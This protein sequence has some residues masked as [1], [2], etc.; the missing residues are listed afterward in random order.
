MSVVVEQPNKFPLG[1]FIGCGCTVLF[2]AVVAIVAAVVLGVFGLLKNSQ[3]F[4]DS[5]A[6]LSANSAAVEA[7]GEPIEAGFFVKGS[8]SIDND[9]GTADF[10]IPVSGPRGEGTIEVEGTKDASG[11]TYQVWELRVVGNPNPIP[12]GN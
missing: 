6:A 4:S 1:K 12:L 7:L 9:T 11:W 10:A 3:P 8:I 2:L 5:M